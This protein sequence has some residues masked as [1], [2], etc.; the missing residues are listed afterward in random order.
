[1]NTIV[2]LSVVCCLV[3]A[4][5]LK[6]NTSK[7]T[8]QLR[9]Q[10]LHS[11]DFDIFWLGQKSAHKLP[12]S[13]V[14]PYTP[15]KSLQ[16]FEVTVASASDSSP[17]DE[18]HIEEAA[19]SNLGQS[20]YAE[21][22]TKKRKRSNNSR[23]VSTTKT[24]EA[25]VSY[26]SS[27]IDSLLANGDNGAT[28]IADVEEPLDQAYSPKPKKRQ[29][30]GKRASIKKK[31]TPKNSAGL[32]AFAPAGTELGISAV[33]GFVPYVPDKTL[34]TAT[35]VK[36]TRAKKVTTPRA[37]RAPKPTAKA[38]A[39]AATTHETLEQN[40][41]N[42]IPAQPELLPASNAAVDPALEANTVV[43]SADG[44][45]G[46]EQQQSLFG[47]GNPDLFGTKPGPGQEIAVQVAE[48]ATKLAARTCGLL[49]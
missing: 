15:N 16:E 3:Q 11:K 33:Q 30:S 49:S 10:I 38:K 6:Y 19:H 42:P 22:D 28:G 26:N 7:L 25:N 21:E 46:A 44:V 40:A 12:D 41:Q 23:R 17:E 37:K 20:Q 43:V 45:S 14:L 1:M 36:A 2:K 35:P 9:S 31:H 47:D 4:L 13:A 29:G 27:T 48:E 24:L 34:T 8:T 39:A 18:N 5:S 32:K